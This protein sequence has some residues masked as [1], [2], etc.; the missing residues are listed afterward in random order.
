M[1]MIANHLVHF[2][3]ERQFKRCMSP[4]FENMVVDARTPP[5][6]GCLQG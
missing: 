4:F 2:I 3:C 1:S 6:A 5:P